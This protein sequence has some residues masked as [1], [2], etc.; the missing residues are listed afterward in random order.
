MYDHQDKT[1]WICKIE[2]YAKLLEYNYAKFHT[3][4]QQF[5]YLLFKWRCQQ[6]LTNISNHI[7]I[8]FKM[9]F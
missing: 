7:I 2:F 6:I 8:I 3:K 5:F 1:N 9:S 4:W